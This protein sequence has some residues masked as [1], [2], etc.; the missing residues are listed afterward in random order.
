MESAL[1]IETLVKIVV[2]RRY[3]FIEPLSFRTFLMFHAS[4]SFH[5]CVSHTTVSQPKSATHTRMYTQTQ[6][7]KPNTEG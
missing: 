5:Y 4:R 1:K 2:K 3:A 6:A 7:T